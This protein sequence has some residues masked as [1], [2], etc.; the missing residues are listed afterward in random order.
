MQALD[1]LLENLKIEEAI[2]CKRL[3]IVDYSFMKDL[4][5]TNG[6]TVRYTYN[7]F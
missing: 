4:P 7:D 3:F 2:L 5:C 1:P 6:R